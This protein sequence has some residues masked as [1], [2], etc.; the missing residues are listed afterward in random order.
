MESHCEE[1]NSQ[2]DLKLVGNWQVVITDR[3]EHILVQSLVP[4]GIFSLQ[5]NVLQA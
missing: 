3:G 5:I 1:N 4:P 2:S